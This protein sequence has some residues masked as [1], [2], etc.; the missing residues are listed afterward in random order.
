MDAWN[1]QENEEM[2]E[3]PKVGNKKPSILLCKKMNISHSTTLTA[4]T[5]FA[6]RQG[7]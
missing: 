1:K 3:R 7:I 5:S 6:T 4:G 2:A